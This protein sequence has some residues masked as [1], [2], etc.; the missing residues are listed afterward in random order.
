MLLPLHGEMK[1]FKVD[2]IG[3]HLGRYKYLITT[4]KIIAAFRIEVCS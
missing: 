1:I 4:Y 2:M 3:Q